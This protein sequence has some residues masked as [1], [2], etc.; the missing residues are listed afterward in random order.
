MKSSDSPST[1]IFEFDILRALAITMLMFHHSEV[2]GYKVFDTT[3]EIIS[4]YIEAI[5]LGIFFFIAGYFV[6]RYFQKHHQGSVSFLFSRM[7]RIIPPYWLALSLYMLILGF[8][9]RKRDLAIYLLGSHFIFAPNFVK[10]IITIWYVGAIVLFYVIFGV[11]LARTS[12]TKGLLLGSALIFGIAYALH[13]WVGLIDERF[14]KYFIVFLIGILFAR[15]ESFS[16]WLSRE[17]L[18]MKFALAFISSFIFSLVIGSNSMSPFYIFGVVFFIITWVVLLF[19][20]ASGIKS[21]SVLKLAGVVS[22]ASFFV[23]LLHRPLWIWLAGIFSV[24]TS[25]YLPFFKMIPASIVVFILS[26][27]LQFGYDRLLAVFRQSR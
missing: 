8:S 3:L 22:Y 21:Q 10:P 12:S 15:L 19:A 26:Y 9:L 6:Q 27:Y 13:Q 17:Q 5:L 25:R 16:H 11:L 2:Y 4:P 18:W 20:L 1:K 23:Y 24:E 7:L 14:Y